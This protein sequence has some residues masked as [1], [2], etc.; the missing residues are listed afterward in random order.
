MTMDLNS[1]RGKRIRALLKSNSAGMTTKGTAED[2]GVSPRVIGH[3]MAALRNI[4]EAVYVAGPMRTGRWCAPE[5]SEKIASIVEMQRSEKFKKKPRREGPRMMDKVI[6]RRQ[7]IL[8]LV[9][10]SGTDGV[11]ISWLCDRMGM[12]V[13]TVS[14]HLQVL[15]SKG[16]IEKS[17]PTG[18]NTL[19]GAPGIEQ[20]HA[21]AWLARSDARAR[22]REQRRLAKEAERQPERSGFTHSI[23]RAIDAP[24]LRPAGPP[25]VW[26]LRT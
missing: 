18:S 5:Y 15:K 10:A 1:T 4:G 19:W 20:K 8:E 9:L 24:P 16:L 12:K 25:S 11:R 21:D 14:N 23:V 3:Y 2:M 7:M 17:V 6:L 26:A 22:R 13:T